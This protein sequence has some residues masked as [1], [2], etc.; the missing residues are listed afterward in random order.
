[1]LNIILNIIGL[2]I[3]FYAI[4]I[5][6][7]EKKR[8]NGIKKDSERVEYDLS[9]DRLEEFSQILEKKE[10]Q[11][12]SEKTFKNDN[13]LNTGLIKNIEKIEFSNSIEDSQYKGIVKDIR[14]NN[15]ASYSNIEILEL[16]KKGYEKIE[17]AKKTGRSIREIEVILKLYKD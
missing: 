10:E 2:I 12:K 11:R 8:T 16:S 9:E 6:K 5:I 1:M 15:K 14:V 7:N 4:I 13:G 3:I 17:I